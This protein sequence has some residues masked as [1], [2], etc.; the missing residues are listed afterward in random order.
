MGPGSRPVTD[1]G[2]DPATIKS[3]VQQHWDGRAPSFDDESQ[4]GIHTDAQHERWLE[5]LRNWAGTDEKKVLDVGCGTGVVSLLLAEVGHHVTGID[6]A[7]SMLAEA[8]AKTAAAS[9]DIDFLRGDAH[10][11]PVAAGT[12]QLLTARHLIW[13]LPEP[14]RAVREWRD[15]LTAD[16]TLLLIEGYWDDMEPWDEYERIHGSLP[17]YEGRPP[18]ELEGIL[19]ANGFDHVSFDELLD[20]VLW[21]REPRHEYYIMRAEVPGDGSA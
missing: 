1:T 13:T 20:P 14:E 5:V 4:H 3:L 17:L 18:A 16:G 8:R 6:F 11:L 12:V 21:G 15:A 9:V 19:L 10:Q 2:P 7:P